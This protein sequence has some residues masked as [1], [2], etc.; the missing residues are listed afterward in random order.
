MQGG[1]PPCS[2]VADI[3]VG[4][5]NFWPPYWPQLGGW[6]VIGQ[7]MIKG[8]MPKKSQS[9]PLIYTESRQISSI[10]DKGL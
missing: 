4:V 7:F 6:G 2:L 3:L 5:Q 1:L 9:L 10:V 8:K